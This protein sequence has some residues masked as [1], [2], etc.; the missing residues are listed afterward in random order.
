MVWFN[1][2]EDG[3]QHLSCPQEKLSRLVHVGLTTSIDTVEKQKDFVNKKGRL[4]K[5][6]SMIVQDGYWTYKEIE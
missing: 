6:G 3:P 2:I 5:D 1:F 4:K